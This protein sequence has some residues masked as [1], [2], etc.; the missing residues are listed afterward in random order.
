MARCRYRSSS[1]SCSRTAKSMKKRMRSAA[2]G[3]Q[4]RMG[5]CQV[6]A[7]GSFKKCWQMVV[8]RGGRLSWKKVTAEGRLSPPRAVT[9]TAA[10]AA[11]L[12]VRR[13]VE[14]SGMVS[15]IDQVYDTPFEVE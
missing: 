10:P 13:L 7:D 14:E 6:G 9:P 3:L 2:R 11:A 8:G 1:G 4:L 15:G 12:D 5:F